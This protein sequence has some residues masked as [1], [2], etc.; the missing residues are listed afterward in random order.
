M[1]NYL[2]EKEYR[3]SPDVV[4]EAY[5]AYQKKYVYPKSYIFMVLFLIVAADF[6]HA[7]VKDNT[8]VLAYILIV[9]CLFF[10][11]REWY[12][13]RRA[14]RGI[15]ESF[16]QLGSP[17]YRLTAAEGYADIATVSLP[18]S[19]DE[20]PDSEN[21]GSGGDIEE[22]GLPEPTRIPF[23]EDF[24]LMECECAFLL[25]SGKSVFYIVPK[26]CLTDGEMDIIRGFKRKETT[27]SP[28]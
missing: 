12:N 2:I 28:T 4:R 16:V 5:R 26:D 8:N 15:T 14:R 18:E 11:F 3:L 10:A 23:D 6:V 13:P 9:L 20:A 25:V 1:E 22:T 21:D 7:A 27:V 17:V 24:T 19:D